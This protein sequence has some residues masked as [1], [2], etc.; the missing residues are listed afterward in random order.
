MIR[1]QIPVALLTAV[2]VLATT[3]AVRACPLCSAPSF[4][5]SERVSQADAVVLVKWKAGRKSDGRIPGTTTYE[6]TQ[7]SKGTKA[8]LKPGKEI[9]LTR[10][11]PGKK[12]DLFLLM[13]TKVVNVEWG[14]PIDVSSTGYKYI[15]NSPH[16]KKPAVERLKYFLKY[17]EFP[18]D[19]IANDA[20]AEFAMAPYKDI[21][22]LTKLLPRERIRKWISSPDTPPTRIGLYGL[23]LGLCGEASDAKLMEK[24][25][26]EKSGDYR[27]GIEGV[28]AGYLMLAGEKGLIILE[29]AKFKDQKVAFSETWA[30]MQAIGFL[31]DFAPGKIKKVR[32]RQSMRLLLNRATTADLVIANLARWKDWSVMDRLM[33]LYGQKDYNIPAIKRS[34]VRFLLVCS[35]DMKADTPP[36]KIPAHVRKA[37]KNLEI[38]RKKDPKTVRAA[39]RF[40]L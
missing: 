19:V 39:E 5:Y 3:A 17:L 35:K 20:Y 15:A 4:T 1:R 40:F 36:S 24:K 26:L 21:A 10:Y 2:A 6:I 7:V 25:I 37:K 28:M 8:V 38:L 16:P 29:D 9:V 31:W 14:S 23:L 33:K 11:R 18:D 34:I 32:L 12:G 30:A 22:K 27:L 13:G